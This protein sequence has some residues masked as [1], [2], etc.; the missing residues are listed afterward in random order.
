MKQKTGKC[1]EK[2]YFLSLK[3]ES[4]LLVISYY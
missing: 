3:D 4:D 2:R 1:D